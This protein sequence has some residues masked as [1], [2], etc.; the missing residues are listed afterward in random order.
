MIECIIFLLKNRHVV[1]NELALRPSERSFILL[2]NKIM[3][4]PCQDTLND[5]KRPEK[6]LR[7]NI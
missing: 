5:V 7:K 6:L 1:Y 4:F 3:R 2:K